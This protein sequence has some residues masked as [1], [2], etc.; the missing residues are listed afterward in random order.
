MGLGTVRDAWTRS[1]EVEY[2]GA[3]AD[4]MGLKQT[5]GGTMRERLMGME[6]MSLLRARRRVPELSSGYAYFERLRAG[7]ERLA[8]RLVADGAVSRSTA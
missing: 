2:E 1:K 3:G 6:G 8:D 5:A 4:R 7:F